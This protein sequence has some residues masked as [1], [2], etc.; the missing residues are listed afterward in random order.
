M[1]LDASVLVAHLDNGDAHHERAVNLLLEAAE[2]SFR[3]SPITLAEVLTGPARIGALNRAKA[4]LA[5]I[6]VRST[7]MADEAPER[8]AA[9]R[10]DTGLKMPDCCV[11]LAAEEEGRELATFD[12]RLA[13]VAKARGIRVRS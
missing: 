11:V 1:I 2:E 7:E 12:D 13:S 4:A 6:G 3:A 5:A 10:A 8:L 9:I